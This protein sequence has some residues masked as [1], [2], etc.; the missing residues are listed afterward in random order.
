[1][2]GFTTQ[3]GFLSW[4]DSHLGVMVQF[5]MLCPVTTLSLE[6]F[7]K[8]GGKE[9]EEGREWDWRMEEEGE[10]REDEGGERL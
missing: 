10:E 3:G 6:Y 2:S 7:V 8:Y 9:Q 5:E 1:M 4:S